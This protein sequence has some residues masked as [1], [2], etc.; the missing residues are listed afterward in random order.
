[1][2]GAQAVK[3]PRRQGGISLIEVLVSVLLLS[4]GILGVASLQMYALKVN[5]EANLQSQA[6]LQVKDLIERV[7][8]N[9]DDRAQ[10]E[11]TS[12]SC[13][14]GS[15]PS[16]EGF[17]HSQLVQWCESVARTLPGGQGQVAVTNGSVDVEVTWLERRDRDDPDP[18]DADAT[19]RR[20]RYSLN[21]RV[22]ND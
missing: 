3:D 20:V 2:T 9:P 14:E 5:S 22:V 1:M 8:L 11:V 4:V 19:E 18:D 21:A 13:R 15:T 10:F 7:R 12:T 16:G 17:A 6:S